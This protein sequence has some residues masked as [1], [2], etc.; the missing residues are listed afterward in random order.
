[1]KS[2]KNAFRITDMNCGRCRQEK[3][4]KRE[5]LVWASKKGEF[6]FTLLCEDC[7]EK[8]ASHRTEDNKPNPGGLK[9]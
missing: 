2:N 7:A 4:V 5:R 1:M 9:T 3:F 6:R 8:T